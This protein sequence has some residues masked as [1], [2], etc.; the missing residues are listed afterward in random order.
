MEHEFRAK[1]SH[2]FVKLGG[3]GLVNCYKKMGSVV[4]DGRCDPFPWWPLGPPILCPRLLPTIFP[5]GGS[6]VMEWAHAEEKRA[7]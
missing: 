5:Q 7:V 3:G 2:V 4:L 6:S 1:R